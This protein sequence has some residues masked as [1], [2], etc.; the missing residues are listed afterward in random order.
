MES[1]YSRRIA[2]WGVFII[3]FSLMLVGLS[4]LLGSV[5]GISRLSVFLAFSFLVAGSLFAIVAVKLSKRASYL[6]FAAFLFMVGFFVFLT[7]LHIIPRLFFFR[8]WPLM[9]VFS[10]LAL[11]PTGLR[12]YGAF[13]S[14]FVVPSCVFL[15]LGIV[16]LIF[17]FRLV[18]FSFKQFILDWWPLFFVL[19][20][21]ILVLGSLDGKNTNGN[22]LPR[23]KT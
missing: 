21:I 8:A 7:A 13:R 12:H 17:S 2:A 15:I 1:K 5:A 6:F 22:R 16:L 18:T 9:S 10:G 19:I 14:K 23:Q 11:L 4:F 3:G 20:G